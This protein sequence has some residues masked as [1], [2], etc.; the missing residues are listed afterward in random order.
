ME[1]ETFAPAF[2]MN[3]LKMT[4]A[5]VLPIFERAEAEFEPAE[6]DAV[7]AVMNALDK[8]DVLYEAYDALYHVSGQWELKPFNADAAV[9]TIY[10]AA[11]EVLYGFWYPAEEKEDY[12]RDGLRVGLD[13][14]PRP[15][16]HDVDFSGLAG[17]GDA[18]ASA[19]A[20]YGWRM[21]DSGN[22]IP[23]RVVT[24]W[25]WWH[26]TAIPEAWHSAPT[27]EIF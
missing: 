13:E 25:E 12:Y 14:S 26:N 16:V 15:L 21:D 20:A 19:A 17:V 18:A 6:R 22:L 23:E 1:F 2:R 24:F 7:Y 5:Y 9:N 8:P 4:A 3:L 11:R 27:T 10:T